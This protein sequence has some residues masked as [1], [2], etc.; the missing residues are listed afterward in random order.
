MQLQS[1][2]RYGTAVAV[3][4][5]IVDELVAGREVGEAG[6]RD[7]VVCFEDLLGTGIRQLAV[8]DDPAETAGGE[9]ELALVRDW[10]TAPASSNVSSGE[11]PSATG[12]ETARPQSIG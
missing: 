6:Y 1:E 8:A 5:R 3:V 12:S 10:L 4:S 11:P 2:N 7:P 9:I